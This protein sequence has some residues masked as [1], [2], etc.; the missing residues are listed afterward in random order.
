M[1]PTQSSWLASVDM[2][3]FGY[4]V[5]GEWFR[6]NRELLLRWQA[7][8][9]FQHDDDGSRREL[10]SRMVD[11]PISREP[12]RDTVTGQGERNAIWCDIEGRL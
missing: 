8:L 3:G 12:K 7:M 10:A 1:G 6:G 2:A 5:D 9:C 4:R 11:E